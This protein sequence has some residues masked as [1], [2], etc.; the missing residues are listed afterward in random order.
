MATQ[1]IEQSLD[2][3]FDVMVSE[4]APVDL[5]LQR[6]GRLQRHH[7]ADRR[8]TSEP[9][10]QVLSPTL[11]DDGP[12]AFERATTYVYDEHILLRTWHVLQ[13]REAIA[14][15]EDIEGLIEEV[16]RE[17]GEPPD[18]APGHLAARWHSTFAEMKRKR[19]RERD[20]AMVPRIPSPSTG[21]RLEDY[22]RDPREE[23]AAD[24]HPAL[25]ALTR[26]AEPSVEVVL[27]PANS[28]LDAAADAVPSLATCRE[29]LRHSVSITAADVVHLLLALPVPHPWKR[30]G[31]LRRLRL[32]SLDENNECRVGNGILRYD[33][34]LGLQIIR[35]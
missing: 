3:D 34:S 23:D 30:S 31:L 33:T 1:V 24:L 20:K 9:V 25:Q 14:V 18:G 17:S 5:L 6:S 21:A 27:L 2:L 16:Y 8:A 7:R 26:L 29:L 35:L 19:Q 11:G 10:L 4:M 15:P 28:P 13:D 22:T 32:L 12:P